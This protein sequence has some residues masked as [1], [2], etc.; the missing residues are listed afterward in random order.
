MSGADEGHGEPAD[1]ADPPTAPIGRLGPVEPGPVERGPVGPGEPLSPG[2][3]STPAERAL[4]AWE[5][6]EA[7]IGATAPYP[8]IPRR[9]HND[10]VGPVV[11]ADFD[12]WDEHGRPG[13][14]PSQAQEI[15]SGP[16]AAFRADTQPRPAQA[17]DDRPVFVDSSGRRSRKWRWAGWVA[18][19]AC[20]GF[21]A[22][23]AGS[24]TGA[25][26]GAPWLRI[27][28]VAVKDDHKTPVTS[29]GTSA[30]PSASPSADP[31]TV[32]TPEG[33]LGETVIPSNSA[34]GK[35]KHTP[36]PSSSDHKPPSTSHSPTHSGGPK[37]P[38]PSDSATAP[39]GPQSTP[40]PS[41]TAGAPDT[42]SSP[43]SD[44][45]G[46]LLGGNSA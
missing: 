25:N 4:K 21:G 7:D 27:P 10:P 9:R 23:L 34:T 30:S 8:V 11:R 19:A 28:G 20:V 43:P 24:M 45:L 5:E 15:I 3:G 18:V 37:K 17:S 16:P 22:T 6:G 36:D 46:G 44:P 38:T 14:A 42:P 12:E 35:P 13:P 26:S 1:Q 29:P 41:D 32:P 33:S 39:G 31:A 2:E 40:G